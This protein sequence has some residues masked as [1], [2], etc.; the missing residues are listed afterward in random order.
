[1]SG[2]E[3]ATARPA[4]RQG[5]CYLLVCLVGDRIQVRSIYPVEFFSRAIDVLV[6]DEGGLDKYGK[7][8]TLRDIL[9]KTALR[10]DYRRDYWLMRLTKTDSHHWKQHLSQSQYG[11]LLRDARGDGQLQ[12]PAEPQPRASTHGVRCSSVRADRAST[13]PISRAA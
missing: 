7:V 4:T 5:E 11:V 3:R 9:P 6:V 13:L 1:M 10:L 12:R 2:D 8:V